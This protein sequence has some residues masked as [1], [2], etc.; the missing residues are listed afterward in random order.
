MA[1]AIAPLFALAGPAQALDFEITGF[2]EP[3]LRVF[4]REGTRP[5]QDWLVNASV[6]TEITFE[7]FWDDGDQSVVVTPFGRLDQRDS[8]RTHIDLREAKYAL[9]RGDWEVRFGVDKVF[10]GVTEAVH[11]IDIINQTDLVENVDGEDKLGQPM[12]L[13]TT[14]QSFGTFDAFFLPF[15]RE[16]TFQD[17]DG[18][19]GTDFPIDVDSP[20]FESSAEEW[21]PDFAFRYSNTF[22]VW[23]VGVSY[24]QGTSREP[25]FLPRLNAAFE[26]V[27]VPFYAQ[28]KQG[29]LDVQATIDAWLLKFEG[30]WRRQLGEDFG[31][32][33]SGFE[34]TFY[35]VFET[36]GD[37]GLVGEY[38]FDSR[39]GSSQNPFANDVFAAVRWTA[40]D[41]GSTAILA[42]SNIDLDT[43][44]FSFSFEGERRIGDDY[45]VS[46][47]GRFFF[48]IPASD[49]LRSFLDDD[50]LQLRV[51][52]FF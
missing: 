15:F 25:I 9:V 20:L 45:M 43:Q 47:E 27:L 46:L 23:D 22:D 40:N 8:N 6:A 21:H 50:F 29:S 34:Y 17:T 4:L 18:R 42:G 13:V 19:P 39:G 44:A 41:A 12:L 7:F 5:E 48:N 38:Y 16:R 2:V 32:F 24:F 26:P 31:T 49:P 37:I 10:W 3:E 14:A 28:I 51:A 33:G 36:P 52:R 35:G 30:Y 11:V 1:S